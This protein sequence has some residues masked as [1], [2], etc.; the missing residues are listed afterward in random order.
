MPLSLDDILKHAHAVEGRANSLADDMAR[1]LNNVR[2]KLTASISTASEKLKTD[3]TN[4]SLKARK[5]ALEAQ[6]AEVDAILTEL[7]QVAFPELLQEVALDTMKAT[8]TATASAIGVKLG[9][10]TD[11]A[12]VALWFESAT[13]D[14]LLAT[15]WLKKLQRNA[16]DRIISVGRQSLIEGIGVQAT[17]RMMKRAGIEGSVPGLRGLA[18]TFLHSATAHA[19][20]RTTEALLGPDLKGWRHVGTLD[21]RTCLRCGPL[22]G[23]VCK[24]DD[25]R[26]VLPLHW[27]CRC[28]YQ[29]VTDLEGGTRPAV[30]HSG[31]KVHHRDGST[32]TKFTVEEVDQVAG[33]TTYNSWLKRQLVEDPAF[34]RRVLGRQRFELFKAGKL[35]LARMTV[36]GRIRRLSEL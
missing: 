30:K 10:G 32:S 18:S 27:R 24:P 2:A 3:W 31:R 22:D 14:G 5:A 6:R 7:Y 9:S 33:S 15:D 21:G 36:N 23:K 20:E 16:A 17:A 11:A 8:E 29:P 34:V 28:I 26:P 35:S 13:V 12:R 4:S 1:E 19:R 25:P